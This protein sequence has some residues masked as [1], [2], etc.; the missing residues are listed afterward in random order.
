[1]PDNS[2]TDLEIRIL[3]KLPEGY[4]IEMTL[5]GQQ[6][7]PRG[8]LTPDLLPWSSSGDLAADGQRLFNALL[9]DA[10]VREAWGQARGQAPQRR[11][12]LRID[13]TAAELHA[14]PWELL[15]DGAS[16]LSAHAD[17]PFS[18]YLPIAQPWSGG[19]DR[20]PIKVLIVISNPD[21]LESKYD[22]PQADV[23]LEEEIL[24]AA[25]EKI[26]PKEMQI[27]FLDEP[28][29]LE[30]LE[31]KIRQGYHLLHFLG[32]GA[33]NAR[34]G[35]AAL[36]LQGE[37]GHAQRV[38]DEEFVGMLARQGVQPRLVFLAAC[39]SATRSTADAY[40]GLGP[41]LVSAGVP[42]VVA[43][44]D[45][46]TVKTARKFSAAFYQRLLEHGQP[47]RA[48]NEA[49]STLLTSGRPDAAVPVLFMRL[50]SGRLWGEE[51]A[52]ADSRSV[53][54]EVPPPPEPVR[55]PDIA[56]FIGRA[57]DLAYFQD[58][59]AQH[60]LAAIV[61]MPGVGKTALAAKL[62]LQTA[63][64]QDIFWHTFNENEG[65]DTVIWKLAGFLAWHDQRELWRML[66]TARQT[67]GQA[68][69]VDVL[70]DYVLQEL[71]RSRY[72]LC[73]DNFHL[74]DHDQKLKRLIR[75]A[76]DSPTLAIVTSH[77]AIDLLDQVDFAP[78]AGLAAE[79]TRALLQARGLSLAD[80][81]I[82][83][84][85][86]QTQGNAEFLTLAIDA[87][88]EAR[89]PD[90]LIADLTAADDVERYLLKEVDS[91]LNDDTRAAM[92]G[93]AILAGYPGSR[94]A[95]EAT[96]DSGSLRRTLRELVD[97]YLVLSVESP[98]TREYM[99]HTVVQAFYYDLMGRSQR[100]EMHRRAAQYYAQ[101]EKDALK[102]AFHYQRAGEYNRSAEQLTAQLW[103]L[104]NQGHAQAVRQLLET[105]TADQLDA[106]L[107]CEVNFARGEV[108]TLLGERQPAQAAYEAAYV[109]A[110]T[111]TLKAKICRG[112]GNLL[113]ASAPRE[114]LTWLQRGVGELA[115]AD[116]ELKGRHEMT[117]GFI[118]SVSEVADVDGELKADLLI[119]LS[120]VQIYLGEHAAAME[121]VQAGLALLPVGVSPARLGALM[122]LGVIYDQ[123]GDSPQAIAYS[124]QALAL[125]QQLNNQFV[126]IGIWNNLGKGRRRLGDWPGAVAAY[127]Q[128]L[129]LA[130]QMGIVSHQIVISLNLAYLQILQD[131]IEAAAALL[132]HNLGLA[133]AGN[134]K[135][136]EMLIQINL[137]EIALLD[138][139]AD[140]AEARLNE[141]EQIAIA[142]E[143]QDQRI[144]I[145]QRRARLSVLRHDLSAAH[146]WAQRAVEQADR[147]GMKLE[148]GV[149]LRVLGD[150]LLAAGER[151]AALAAWEQSAALT[152]GDPYE[153]ACTQREW[154][155]A[156]RA[157]APD[158]AEELLQ[159][160]R[161][162]FER[163]GARRDRA[164]C[165]GG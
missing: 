80:E 37:D 30:R 116:S 48:V 145:D 101:E 119:K 152:A 121:T 94:E 19:I 39:Q 159:A 68:P 15:H 139:Q 73:F 146:S 83:R 90:R 148:Q 57:A 149:S 75:P 144:E 53:V 134:L 96:L 147:L 93:V 87:L 36:Y 31:E 59:L 113:R 58:K 157:A 143:N 49:R 107:W 17:T 1:M 21:D 23:A 136:F 50:K 84:L 165:D 89:Y 127:Q 64:P 163:L 86:A 161:S 124:E 29:T 106:A 42:A 155:R 142:I 71:R 61:G 4:P 91:V 35:Q 54:P 7:F 85:Y 122:N 45:T 120:T 154:G 74:V 109:T 123:L 70:L 18:R 56:H 13:P 100:R 88:R 156:L 162:T 111:R 138:K 78:L 16:L 22:L 65:V 33:F 43:M 25:F 79:D 158:R 10:Q 131:E 40:L 11:I 63:A 14:L 125:G 132:R 164:A 60:R 62:A 66:Q 160:A 115:D 129:A 28:I 151:E 135:R 47:D 141:A 44:Q 67:G 72:V 24:E 140:D 92:N 99:L 133:R 69:P 130:R 97:R 112:M 77:R 82:T 95:I 98:Q 34:R 46:V 9:A 126:L 38:I 51:P 104:I 12:R 6:E 26:D 103:P 81:Q 2:F 102:A 27:D 3:Q 76:P 110:T 137:A 105:F 20:R 108:Y 55:P 128:G 8:H 114:A 150:V 118:T 41:K 117:R 153:A 32:H 52:G 5:G